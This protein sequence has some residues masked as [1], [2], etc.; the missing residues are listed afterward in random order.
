M[1]TGV[2][3]TQSEWGPRTLP[4]REY[5]LREFWVI[6]VDDRTFH[7]DSLYWHA[8]VQSKAV[9]FCA[10]T[11]MDKIHG[12]VEEEKWVGSKIC[13]MH[14]DV[15]QDG[16]DRVAEAHSRN[17]GVPEARD[18]FHYVVRKLGMCRNFRR[19]RVGIRKHNYRARRRSDGQGFGSRNLYS[20]R[21]VVEYAVVFRAHGRIKHCKAKK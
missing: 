10:I 15:H 14:V 11:V 8:N 7:S 3:W 16:A 9:F 12:W 17:A 20:V 19:P 5:L 18:V 4:L 1:A 13:G 21:C 2:T 6:F